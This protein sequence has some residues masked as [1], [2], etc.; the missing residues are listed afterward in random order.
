MKK[1]HETPLVDSAVLLQHSCKSALPYLA[2][3]FM[4]AFQKTFEGPSF[5]FVV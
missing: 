1:F 3:I 2:D 4:A 5:L